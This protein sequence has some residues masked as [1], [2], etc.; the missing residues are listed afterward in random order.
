M[1][2]SGN[3]IAKRPRAGSA[4]ERERERRERERRPTVADGAGMWTDLRLSRVAVQR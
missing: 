4:R 3:G 2:G 1:V